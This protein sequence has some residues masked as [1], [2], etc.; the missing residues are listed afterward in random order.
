MYNVQ[1]ITLCGRQFYVL[2]DGTVFKQNGKPLTN[3]TDTYGYK[4]IK[5]K[6][7]ET[8]RRKKYLV[9]RL[10]A[11]C[12]IPNCDALP[13]INHKDGNKSN[14]SVDNLEWVTASENQSH[15][16]YVLG[17]ITGFAD[18]PVRCVSTG[19]TYASTRDAWRSTGINYCH[20]SEAARGKR[21]TAGGF[22]WERAEANI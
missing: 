13:Q 2:D 21:K 19:V 17:N 3:Y 22:C 15:S 10:V 18:T 11:E 7:A 4:Y 12:Y 5:I 8:N 1:P 6:N 20:I 16:R 14:N 9:H